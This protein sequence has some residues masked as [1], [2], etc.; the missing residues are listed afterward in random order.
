MFDRG[1]FSIS[2][3]ALVLLLSAYLGGQL[4]FGGVLFIGGATFGLFLFHIAAVMALAGTA[5]YLVRVNGLSLRALG[6]RGAQGRWYFIA[7]LGVI[8]ALLLTTLIG[9]SLSLE[10]R[11]AL[12]GHNQDFLGLQT[13]GAIAISFVT[14]CL[15]V[16]VL[17]E[18]LFRGAIFGYL[19]ERLGVSLALWGSSILFAATHLSV[20]LIMPGA[21]DQ[22]VIALALGQVGLWAA[23]L[24][25]F[26][27]SLLPAIVFHGGYNSL[28]LLMQIASTLVEAP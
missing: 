22:L 28:V 13:R 23:L 15:L 8:A 17:E 21:F 3:P 19:R 12:Q 27:G 2:A 4:L 10:G 20:L 6:L 25:H 14:L 7:C 24:R 5:A 1:P 9:A 11:E 18:A 26:S 16:P